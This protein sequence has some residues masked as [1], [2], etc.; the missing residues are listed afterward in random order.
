MF[1]I[2]AYLQSSSLA[3]L[4]IDFRNEHRQAFGVPIP[5][6]F[7]ASENRQNVCTRIFL[8]FELVV[9]RY[10][11]I[12]VYVGHGNRNSAACQT[13]SIGNC[14]GE[15]F[16]AG[17]VLSRIV[18]KPLPFGAHLDSSSL[19]TL[20]PC[21][22]Q[23]QLVSIRIKIAPVAVVFQHCQRIVCRIFPDE[24]LI[25]PNH[26]G[27]GLIIGHGNGD[28]RR[29]QTSG[30]VGNRV[31]KIF[32]AEEI[33]ERRVA[34]FFP[35]NPHFSAVGG[36]SDGCN[37]QRFVSIGFR[38]IV[39]EN[40]NPRLRRIFGHFGLVIR[41]RRGIVARLNFHRDQRLRLPSVPVSDR[42]AEL[43]DTEKI[44]RRRINRQ[45]SPNA[46]RSS[47]I[48][49]RHQS[50][51]QRFPFIRMNG[52]VRQNGDFI[53]RTVFRN[54]NGVIQR[55]GRIVFRIH[56]H[57]HSTHCRQPIAVFNDV[58]EFLHPVKIWQRAVQH[59]RFPEAK[60]SSRGTFRN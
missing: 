17:E 45:R 49:L 30:A 51:R 13:L 42:I 15:S 59:R 48:S 47:K 54:R 52:I 32:N 36:R 27:V 18:K 11:R 19:R 58:S 29:C 26:W 2:L 34:N 3:G 39:G 37:G 9:Q 28:L 21:L 1:F 57:T 14:V 24:E 53:F 55:R 25:V 6:A 38:R 5:S 35:D 50:Y 23:N 16:L 20:R 22:N 40:V 10:R 41:R 60:L 46:H 8:H 43:F 12:I 4:R 33:G 44:R 56:F 7:F 31:K